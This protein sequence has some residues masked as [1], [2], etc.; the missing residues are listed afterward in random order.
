MNLKIVLNYDIYKGDLAGYCFSGRAADSGNKFYP[1]FSIRMF[2]NRQKAAGS[3]NFLD[4]ITQ[5][6]SM[7]LNVA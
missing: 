1:I 6:N 5:G 3:I 2:E 4:R 7:I